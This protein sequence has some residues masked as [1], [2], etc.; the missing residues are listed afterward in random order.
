MPRQHTIVGI[1]AGLLAEY[2]DR[3]APAGLALLAPLHAVRLGQR[4][5]A[6]TRIGQDPAAGQLQDLLR[7]TGIDTT[8]FQFDPDLGTGRLTVRSIGGSVKRSLDAQAA[9]DNLQWDFDLDDVAQ[10]TDA[11]VFGA[12]GCRSGQSRT[13]VERFLEA[14]GSSL[15]LAD[16]TD[17]TTAGLDRAAALGLL[18]WAEGVALTGQGLEE[19]LP[20][21]DASERAGALAEL[22]RVGTLTFA[23]LADAGAPL[24][25]HTADGHWSGQA[26]VQ[27]DGHEAA[28]VGLTEALLSGADWP[29]CLK[30]VDEFVSFTEQHPDEPMPERGC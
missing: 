6:V 26:A 19:L 11:V 7:E 25:V 18:Q 12:L 8:H 30:R 9:F 4:G 29:A 20:G 1:G 15:R 22:V 2:P 10:E 23:V 27:P 21:H 17:L 13:V 3:D 24:S 16:L 14:C 5:I 28:L